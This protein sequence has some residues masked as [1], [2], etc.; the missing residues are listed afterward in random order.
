ML[1][2]NPYPLPSND[3]DQ[4][5]R[6]F[7]SYIS[8]ED[9]ALLTSL[10]PVKGTAQAIINNLILNF[11]HDLRDLGITF[12][13]PDADD[14]LTVLCERR[15]LSDEQIVRLRRTTVGT[16]SQIPTWLQQHRRRTELRKTA[17]NASPESSNVP[18]HVAK[19]ER[20][21]RKE[22][23]NSTPS[24]PHKETTNERSRYTK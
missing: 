7:Q 16:T 2:K 17:S 9:K 10:R 8:A 18:K 23:T 13:R 22:T 6:R 15:P 14:I 12:Y 11:C 24:E 5:A 20:G 21:H 19:G 1:L 4:D 3:D